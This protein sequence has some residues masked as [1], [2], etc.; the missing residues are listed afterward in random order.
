MLVCGW[1][2][3]HWL[4]GQWLS[5]ERLLGSRRFGTRSKIAAAH[6]RTT[7]C[8]GRWLDQ[9][10]RN[11][12]RRRGRLRLRRSLASHKFGLARCTAAKRRIVGGAHDVG[13]R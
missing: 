12:G 3:G 11:G 1:L 6:T 2:W 9:R 4:L 7:S 8:G 10:L 5:G 13:L